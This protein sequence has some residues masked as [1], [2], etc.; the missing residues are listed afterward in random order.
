[1]KQVLVVDDDLEFSHAL[2]TLLRVRNYSVRVTHN[3]H[4]A[5][6]ALLEQAPDIVLADVSMPE[7]NG[8]ELCERV[9]QEPRLEL[10]PFIFLSARTSPQD[11]VLGLR[12][13]ADD[14]IVKPFESEEL[15]AR[16][17]NLIERTRRMLAEI[18]RLVRHGA[19]THHCGGQEAGGL[20][21]N[22][23]LASLSRAELQVF[24]LVAQGLTNRAIAEHL[25]LS[26]RTVQGHVANIRA[27]LNLPRR[28]SILQF[29]YQNRL[30]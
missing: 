4:S 2:S 17:E 30:I 26:M 18:H 5:L 10:L 9:R 15:I 13:G 20:R 28:E 22:S 24:E 7:M 8:L 6:S 3:G 12:Q 21:T 23:P 1:M 11:R 25:H 14:Y 16:M 19:T 27:K 29:A